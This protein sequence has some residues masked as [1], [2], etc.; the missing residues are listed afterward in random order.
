VTTPE[1]VQASITMGMRRR[2]AL[3][4]CA[5]FAG[6]VGAPPDDGGESTQVTAQAVRCPPRI[7]RYPIAGPHNGGYDRNWSNF[8]CHPHP[9]DAPDNSDY[10]GAHH[11]NDLF[12]LRGTPAVA[13]RDGVVTRSGVASSTSGNRVS[14][15]DEC[16]WSYYLGH[17]DTIA[18]GIAPGARVRAGQVIGTVGNT[19]ATG[20]APHIHFNVHRDGDY[21]NDTDPFPLLQ[22]ADATACG[23]RCTP[24]CEGSV[25]VGGNCGRG[26]CAVFGSRC[27]SDGL[28]ARCAFYACPDRG[29]VDVCL[30]ATH[31]AHCSNGSVAP[32]GDCGA[33]GS[34]CVRDELGARCAFVF[35]PTRGEADVCWG[36]SRIGHC[37]DGALTG[38][39][40]CAAYG[41]ICSTVVADRARCMS[42]FCV[43]NPTETP[44]VHDACLPDGRLATCNAVGG[45]ENLRGC[46]AG[47]RCEN[48][49]GVGRCVDPTPA[50]DA[51]TPTADAP[52][53][54]MDDAGTPVDDV[55][56]MP[57]DIPLIPEDLAL[58]PVDTVIP[59]EDAGVADADDAGDDRA[60]IEGGCGCRASGA[61]L[62][63]RWGAAWGALAGLAWARRRRP[64]SGGRGSLLR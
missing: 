16:G 4:C 41:A 57:M 51:G 21:N 27:V 42:V 24:H 59:I 56:T 23:M 1:G 36:L 20:T 55:P 22:A 12:A 38:Q 49:D 2:W 53:M 7:D 52:T 14:I 54:P 64:S 45:L 10:G 46:P 9:G 58:V 40:D 43:S 29:E 17:L 48:V 3:G 5:A 28:G 62:G 25:V 30:D 37:R 6:C 61:P 11:G 34:R 26:D 18:G 63:G 50:V 32:P 15:E 35:C 33:F 31:I 60:A 8:A 44:R 19:G 39:G 13:P 47:T